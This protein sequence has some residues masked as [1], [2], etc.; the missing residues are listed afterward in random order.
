QLRPELWWTEPS[1]WPSDPIL[2][3]KRFAIFLG[4]LPYEP[5]SHRSPKLIARSEEQPA[6]PSKQPSQVLQRQLRDAQWGEPTETAKYHRLRRLCEKKRSGKLLVP[7]QVAADYKA[8]GD[9]RQKLM[10]QFG[11]CGWSKD[12][13][14]AVVNRQHKKTRENENKQRYAWHTEKTMATEL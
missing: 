10:D 9:A 1:S 2:S 3:P 13:F 7:E 11:E 6:D 5:A 4:D 14:I 8:G 12:R